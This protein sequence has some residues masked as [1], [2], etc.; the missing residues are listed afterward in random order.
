MLCTARQMMNAERRPPTVSRPRRSSGCTLYRTRSATPFIP[1]R[2]R[3]V[4]C[5]VGPPCL[6]L[7]GWAAAADPGDRRRCRR[8]WFAGDPHGSRPVSPASAGL[9]AAVIYYCLTFERRLEILSVRPRRRRRADED[10]R[11][12]RLSHRSTAPLIGPGGLPLIV[13]PVCRPFDWTRTARI[14]AVSERPSAVVAGRATPHIAHRQKVDRR[15]SAWR[16]GDGRT[17]SR[18][19]PRTAAGRGTRARRTRAGSRRH[20]GA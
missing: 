1:S 4:F 19:I 7:P 18:A 9:R 12:R 10:R 15:V 6:R 8:E 2:H 14:N 3:D 13:K 5:N 17:S 20:G 16:P 11:R